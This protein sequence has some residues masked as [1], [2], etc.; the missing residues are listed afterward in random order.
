M[1]FIVYSLIK[2]KTICYWK[3][4]F[5]YI[6]G[7]VVHMNIVAASALPDAFYMANYNITF[8]CKRN[9]SKN[10]T[11]QT[12]NFQYLYLKLVKFKIV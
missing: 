4:I 9:I 7:I 11:L 6:S 1:I 3:Y 10:C 8:F 2:I 5:I 12:F